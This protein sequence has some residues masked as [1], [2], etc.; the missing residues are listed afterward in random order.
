MLRTNIIE[1]NPTKQQVKILKEMLVR[2]SASWNI[3]NFQKRQAF[4]KKEHPFPSYSKQCE[5]LK[6][7]VLYT[8]LGSAYS[9]QILKKLSTSWQSFWNSLTSE[10]VE[11]TVSIP[12][13]FKNYKTKQTLP[14]L[15]ICRNDCYRIDTTFIYISCSKDLAKVNK[16]KG[17]LKIRYNGLRKWKGMKKTME[18]KY[19]P[20]SKK[21]YAYQTEEVPSTPIETEQQNICSIDLGIKR[22]IT[23]Y[24]KNSN[25][26]CL[27]YESNHIFKNYLRISKKIAYYQAIAKKENNKN[28][29]HRIRH[30]YLKRK[31]QLMNY[32][33]N[34]LAH[35]FRKLQT[36]KIS[37]I[38]LGE[39][40]GIRNSPIPPHYRNKKKIHTMIQNF[41]S[42]N[43]FL[44]KLQNKCEELGITLIPVNEAD[45]S[46]T[47]PICKNPVEAN[48]R[49]FQCP[50]C[51]YTQDRD[52]V[53]C[54]NILDDYIH[55][56]DI[57]DIRVE[58]YPVV[59]TIVIE[60]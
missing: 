1:L 50:H 51:G 57:D 56:Y 13:Y 21:F 60:S 35:L 17:L 4:F 22:Y 38:V 3:G 18:I 9:Q 46:S 28:S 19:F 23:A 55:D 26:F 37:T 14:K 12:S 24:I 20:Y 27:L 15:L 52:V 59:S 48:D 58:T 11:H 44:K 54:I 53:R 36:Y 45:T 16:I 39:L 43:L 29:T 42:Y 10:K 33:N 40:K 8:S 30:L 2:S 25:D 5:G 6:T 49:K 41:W 7:H 32:L 47:C 34:I 31:R